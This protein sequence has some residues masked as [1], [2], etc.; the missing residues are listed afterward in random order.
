MGVN[1]NNNWPSLLSKQ[2]A[3]TNFVKGK[4]EIK[5]SLKAME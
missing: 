4:T 3:A 2:P 5:A 1:E